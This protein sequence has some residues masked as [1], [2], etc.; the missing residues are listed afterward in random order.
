MEGEGDAFMAAFALE[1]SH[2][3]LVA[4][5]F[6]IELLDGEKDVCIAFDRL[7]IQQDVS[8]HGPVV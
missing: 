5:L 8:L 6:P 3:R 2:L 7:S 1:E 4:G